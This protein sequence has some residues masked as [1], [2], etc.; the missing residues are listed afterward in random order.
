MKFKLTCAKFLFTKDEAKKYE[1]LGFTFEDHKYYYRPGP[2][3]KKIIEDPDLTIE[4]STLEELLVFQ[5]EWGDFV[6]LGDSIKLYD[7]SL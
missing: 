1:T 5:E 7:D 6:L 3:K 4:I 2:W